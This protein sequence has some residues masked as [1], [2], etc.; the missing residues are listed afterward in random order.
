MVRNSSLISQLDMR[1]FYWRRTFLLGG[2]M[3]RWHTSSQRIVYIYFVKSTSALNVSKC[4]IASAAPVIQSL[5]LK[6][7]E[8]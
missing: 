7:R 5:G 8:L 6:I 4:L 1:D 3:H 2:M